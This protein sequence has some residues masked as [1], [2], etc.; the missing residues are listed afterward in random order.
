M[1]QDERIRRNFEQYSQ[2]LDS[3]IEAIEQENKES[4]QNDL[5]LKKT[6]R[7]GIIQSF[8]YTFEILWKLLKRI[9]DDQMIL[10][11][12]PK[13]AFKSAFKLGL[14]AEDKEEIFNQILLK[15]NLT[16]H[17]Y[18]ET[19]IEDILDFVKSQAVESFKKIKLSIDDY[20][21]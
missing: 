20:I 5:K 16:S 14:I 3:L 2:A 8:E 17:T 21:V 10:A 7:A 11:N 13:S 4:V 15:R 6:V 1:V 19:I 18:N 12:S 9:A